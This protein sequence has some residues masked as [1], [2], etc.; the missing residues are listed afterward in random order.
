MTQYFTIIRLC[1]GS[2][3]I[4]F[5][6]ITEYFTNIIL[7][8]NE[9]YYYYSRQASLRRDF[10]QASHALSFAQDEVIAARKR[11]ALVQRVGTAIGAEERGVWKARQ[12]H[13]RS[14]GMTVAGD[15]LLAAAFATLGGSFDCG[16]GIA[17]SML[18]PDMPGHIDA[19][20]LMYCSASALLSAGW[21]IGPREKVWREEWLP[22]LIMRGI[23]VSESVD[24]LGE[25]LFL[26]VFII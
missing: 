25:F 1:D 12:A 26:F 6:R 14:T 11:L 5:D 24:P 7:L 16:D 2:F 17:S 10:L 19:D 22:D 4:S 13:L 3:Y 20:S 21:T 8:F 18:R 23:A 15:C 9:Y